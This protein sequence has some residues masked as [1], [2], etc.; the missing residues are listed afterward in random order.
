MLSKNIMV[1]LLG[2]LPL[3]KVYSQK[4]GLF[5]RKFTK[6][7]FEVTYFGHALQTIKQKINESK[8]DLI[9]AHFAYPEGF[10]GA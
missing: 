1:Y 8:I 7:I 5:T 6:I 10:I 2:G 9:H 3:L 4:P